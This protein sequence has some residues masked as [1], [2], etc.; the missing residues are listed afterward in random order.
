[1]TP[2]PRINPQ[3]ASVIPP[4]RADLAFPE[5]SSAMLARIATYGHKEH[6]IPHEPLWK[7]GQ[8]DVDLFVV[9]SGE[10][11]IT[12]QDDREAHRVLARLRAGQFSG[13]LDL[14]SSRHTLVDGSTLTDCELLRIPRAN[15]RRLMKSEGEF[16]NLIMQAAIWRRLG[17]LER[18]S[19]SITLVGE[20]T[21]SDTLLLQTFLSRN[22]Y[23]YR[24]LEPSA[25]G[26]A[27]YEWLPSGEIHLNLPTVVLPDG[28]ILERPATYTLADELGLTEPLSEQETFDVV[29]VGAGPSGLAAAVYAASEGLKTIVI[30][31][32]GPG[33]QAGASSKIENYLGFP[34]GVSGQELAARAQAQAQKFGAR[35]FVSREVRSIGRIGQIF[36]MGLS[37]RSQLR[38]RSVILATGAQYRKLTAE[39][40]SKYEG[41]GI[42]YAA[43]GIEALL[44]G[45]QEIVVVGGGNSAGQ[46]AIYLS[47]FSAHV[48]MIVRARDL[49]I[50]MSDYLV[51]RIVTSHKITVYLSSEVTKVD[52]NTDLDLVT[53]VDRRTQAVHERRINNMF[54][55]I[56]AEPN[57]G[58]LYGTVAL[59]SKG[60]VQT[61]TSIKSTSR[62]GTSLEGVFA[63]GDVREGSIKRVA[64]AVG[65]GA[66][67]VSDLHLYLL[68][69]ANSRGVSQHSGESVVVLNNQ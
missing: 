51:S 45:N 21:S 63:V 20:H 1:V 40:Y 24:L 47:G 25:E 6:Y 17:I 12:A 43:T 29:V 16:A 50:S 22:G 18:A 30:D 46:A 65:E 10:V 59:N 42:H 11:E 35:L 54:V 66:S 8:R 2:E 52:G 5:L 3:E 62:F 39:N 15:L 44:C 69:Y 28:R 31:G 68:D 60:F 57:S 34:T 13:E 9:L 14:L 64:S 41:R 4:F 53:W 61:G 67:V 19:A 56:G 49:G 33:G 7:R 32:L 58:W 27:A 37:D 48:H 55:M 36:L 23:P 26:L 38:S